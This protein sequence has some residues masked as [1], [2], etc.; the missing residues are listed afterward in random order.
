MAFLKVT[1]FA[2]K[3]L[4]IR[5]MKEPLGGSISGQDDNTKTDFT[6]VETV[7]AAERLNA[8]VGLFLTIL[9]GVS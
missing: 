8:G 2:L 1:A 7:A 5:K 9:D 6:G 3:R 4:S